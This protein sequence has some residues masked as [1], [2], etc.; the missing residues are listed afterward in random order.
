MKDHCSTGAAL[1]AHTFATYPH[2]E[3]ICLITRHVYA[4]MDMSFLLY[5]VNS[6]LSGASVSSG[7]SPHSC[8]NGGPVS[9][10]AHPLLHLATYH[11][12]L[13]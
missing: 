2:M 8:S 1:L 12:H 9:A 4:V 5:L 10:A 11:I 7:D 3:H 6:H 13:K